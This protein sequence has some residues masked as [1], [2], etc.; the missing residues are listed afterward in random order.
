MQSS[1]RITERSWHIA[2]ALLESLWGRSPLWPT[3]PT[4]PPRRGTTA[5]RLLSP[6]N[7]QRESAYGFLAYPACV[8]PEA[9][10]AVCHATGALALFVLSVLSMG[11]EVLYPS[12]EG[13]A[14]LSGGIG[15]LVNILRSASMCGYVPF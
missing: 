7:V 3:K 1:R 9:S 12:R 2:L 5:P 8:L 14:A 11:P 10:D 15:N 4:P 6:P 13:Q